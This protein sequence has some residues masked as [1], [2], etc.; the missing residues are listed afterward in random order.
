MNGN[1]QS[2]FAFIFADCDMIDT[3]AAD[4]HWLFLDDRIILPRS[5]LLC[6]CFNGNGKWEENAYS[7]VANF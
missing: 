7:T 5:I 3:T 1:N 6:I 2:I 4:L